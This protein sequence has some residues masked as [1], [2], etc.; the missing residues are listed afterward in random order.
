MMM[1]TYFPKEVNQLQMECLKI[2]S[3]SQKPELEIAVGKLLVAR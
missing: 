1:L 2:K 3:K